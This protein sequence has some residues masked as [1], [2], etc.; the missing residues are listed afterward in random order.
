M[1]NHNR[2][3]PKG[4]A[5]KAP[6]REPVRV[7]TEQTLAA[8]GDAVARHPDGRVIFVQGAAPG[9]AVDVQIKQD[10]KSFLRAKVTSVVEPSPDRVEAR[11]PHYNEC[12]GCSLQHISQPAQLQSKQAWLQDSLQRLAKIDL[13]GVQ[14]DAPWSGSPYGYRTRVRLVAS[15]DGRL[16]FRAPKSRYVVDVRQC[17]VLSP[18]LQDVLTTL[19]A[20]LGTVPAGRSK[21][22]NAAD[23][24]ISLVSNDDG[25][26]AHFPKSLNRVANTV[27]KASGPTLTHGDQALAESTDGHGP[28]FVSPR[29][30]AQSSREGNDALIEYL[31]ACLPEKSDRGLD[32]YSGSGNFTRVLATRCEQVE[33]FEGAREAVAL[34]RRAAADN[35]QVH[36]GP[37]E[38]KLRAWCEG[39]DKAQVV[40]MDPPRAG[41]PDAVL[42]D[43]L[44]VAPEYLLYVS[45]NPATFARDAQKLQAGGLHLRR[46][47]VFDLYPQTGHAE[48]VGVFLKETPAAEPTSH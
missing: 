24:E 7:T 43:V 30:F 37:V 16:G 17:P 8:G 22:A 32:L 36:L 12:G 26:L 5:A 1:P 10:N 42:Q 21:G 6:S 40:V 39:P 11:C 38:D 9:E 45:C 29:V 33:A 3:A 31:K 14:M 23:D 25:V 13:G 44:Q 2:R 28:M 47:R 4:A 15:R 34:A 18:D 48:V 20:A 41:V 19:K 27:A 46:A 35:V